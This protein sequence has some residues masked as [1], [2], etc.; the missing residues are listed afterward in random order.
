MPKP[1]SET[2]GRLCY[3]VLSC[4]CC[5][6]LRFAYSLVIPFYLIRSGLTGVS[7]FD[8]VT[9]LRP[10]VSACSGSPESKSTG[11]GKE[12]APCL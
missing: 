8:F 2:K 7:V 3:L 12:A 10:F 6:W 1:H 11:K 9:S 5:L 4:Y